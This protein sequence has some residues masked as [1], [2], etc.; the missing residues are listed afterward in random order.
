M[1][2]LC[3]PGGAQPDAKAAVGSLRTA[4][5]GARGNGGAAAAAQLRTAAEVAEV[6][7]VREVLGACQ[8]WDGR[9]V[10]YNPKAAGGLG[11]YEVAP[12]AGVPRTQRQLVAELCE[13]GWLFRCA[14]AGLLHATPS[15]RC[16]ASLQ[17]AL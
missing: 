17:I 15:P 9:F 4:V 13:L 14:C 7:L 1:A 2:L 11:A 12:D 8:G 16:P 5:T 10:R 6:A 3:T